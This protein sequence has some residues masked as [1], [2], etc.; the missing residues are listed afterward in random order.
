MN[1]LFFIADYVAKPH[2]EMKRSEI[3]LR[4]A[5]F[6]GSHACMNELFF[7]TAYVAKPH[8]EMKRSG[9]ELRL[10][11]FQR[12][13]CLHERAQAPPPSHTQKGKG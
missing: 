8:S 5:E 6:Q 3:E 9:I 10:A 12:A 13:P 11:E 4:L 7:L 2:S 1:E